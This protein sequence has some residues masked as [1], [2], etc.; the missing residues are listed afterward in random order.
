MHHILAPLRLLHRELY[1][2]GPGIVPAV[3]SRYRI[4]CAWLI[5]LLC[6]AITVFD[7]ARRRWLGGVLWSAAAVALF[8]G[9]ESDARLWGTS[10]TVILGCAA[11]VLAAAAVVETLVQE[12]R[13][14]LSN[15]RRE[16]H[17]YRRVQPGTA[18]PPRRQ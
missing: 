1:L 5:V 9:F 12:M 13:I 15:A 10:T 2:L 3:L 8:N 7:L 4:Q 14:S 17:E 6:I 11:I 18:I 16:R